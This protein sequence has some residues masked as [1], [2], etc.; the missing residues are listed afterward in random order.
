M[1]PQMWLLLSTRINEVLSRAG[2][3]G[4]VVTHGTSTLE[5]TVY[6]L[7]LTI[8]GSKPVVLVGGGVTRDL[9]ATATQTFAVVEPSSG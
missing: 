8:T 9:S 5:E 1:T 2:I 4:V 3:A 6:S 7:D